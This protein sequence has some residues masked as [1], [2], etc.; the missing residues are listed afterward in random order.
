MRSHKAV[1]T[2][3]QLQRASEAFI[4]FKIRIFISDR[5]LLGLKFTGAFGFTKNLN[6]NKYKSGIMIEF[7]MYTAIF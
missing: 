1:S 6:K 2:L 3:F 4:G 5:I 7:E